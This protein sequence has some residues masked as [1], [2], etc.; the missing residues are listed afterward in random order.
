MTTE[1]TRDPGSS[2]HHQ[3]SSVIRSGIHSGRY[4]EGSLLPGETTMM[5]MFGVS[6]ATVRRALQTLEGEGLIQ[7]RQ[8]KG[9]RVVYQP[10]KRAGH[11]VD[12]HIHR[13]EQVAAR[14]QVEVLD[15]D[16]VIPPPTV[17][18]A[19]MLAGGE[20]ALRI[21]RIRSAEGRAL[22]YLVNHVAAELGER[23]RREQ[24]EGPTLVTILREIGRLPRRFDD[25][26]GAVLADPDLA[27][28]L[29]VRIGAPLVEM[30]RTMFDGTGK[31]IAHQ[32]TVIPPDRGKLRTSIESPD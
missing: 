24:F 1:L 14:T 32:W 4:A 22:R 29:D 7:R 31:P 9:T 13:M 11:T 18:E 17:Q 27:R 25:E 6:R 26:V 23:M 16:W 21:V 30:A 2:L 8:G 19:L 20:R 28:A 15:F 5:D 3:I 10:D 12:Q